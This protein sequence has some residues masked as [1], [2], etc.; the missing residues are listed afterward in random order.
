M[1]SNVQLRLARCFLWYH[2]SIAACRELVKGDVLV[3]VTSGDPQIILQFDVSAHRTSQVDGELLPYCNLM[4]MVLPCWIGM[5]ECCQSVLT[6][7][8]QKPMVLTLPCTCTKNMRTCV[9][10]RV[11]SSSHRPSWMHARQPTSTALRLESVETGSLT[12]DLHFALYCTPYYGTY[13]KMKP[14]SLP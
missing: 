12:A 14:I 2:M 8:L 1:E 9:M 13:L 11:L 3:P 6:T 7:L 5:H 4:A 10:D